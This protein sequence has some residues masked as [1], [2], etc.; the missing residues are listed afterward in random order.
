MSN[1]KNKKILFIRPC[2]FGYEKEIENMMVSMG[3]SVDCYNE[4]PSN[5]FWMKV[6]I[7]LKLQSLIKTLIKRHYDSILNDI[8]SVNY[9]YVFIIKLETINKG[10]LKKL[11]ASQK[12]AEFILYLWDSIR[13]YKGKERL[14]PFFDKSYSFD[15]VDVNRHAKLELLPLFYIP[16][17]EQASA[18]H[19]EYDVCFA[20]SGHSDRYKQIKEVKECIK[21]LGLNMYSYIY[22][23]SKWIFYVRKLFDSR[24]RKASI[25][26]FSFSS[27]S[28]NQI[29]DIVTKSK[30]VLDIEHPGQTGLTM[31]TIEMLGLKKKMITTNASVKEYDFYNANNI[32]VI[33]RNNVELNK[34]FINSPYVELDTNIY[35]KYSLKNWLATIF[36]E[37][38]FN[39]SA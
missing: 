8:Q 35:E 26:D 27:L 9:D 7:R 34:K 39:K 12:E 16:L 33:N 30:A 37:K 36:D 10:I 31:R 19:F 1:L 5:S 13:N 14:L 21:A 20:G 38:T 23:P 4:R 2:F 24:M 3:A 25:V 29:M 22:L 6:L 15:K 18:D 11:K 32:C 28:Q 17:Y